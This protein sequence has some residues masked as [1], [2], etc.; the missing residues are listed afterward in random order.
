MDGFRKLTQRLTLLAGLWLLT[1]T[2][3]GCLLFGSGYVNQSIMFSKFWVTTPLIP[4]SPYWQQEIEDTMWEEERY[5]KVPILDP[6]EGENAPLFCMDE[7]S[8]DEVMRAMPDDTKGG[9]PFFAE[10]QR[11]NVRIVT[12]LIVDKL[13]PCRFYP[14]VGPARKHD[15]HYKCTIYYEKVLHSDWPI[16]FSHTDN[17]VEVVYIDHDHLIRCAGPEAG[18]Y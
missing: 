16:P 3:S 6:V 1:G 17:V 11:N 4:V 14:M 15:C 8:P 7:P 10:T 12:D 13:D 5:S 2:S 9:L 18:V